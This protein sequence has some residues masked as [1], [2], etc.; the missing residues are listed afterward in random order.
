MD[1]QEIK[2]KVISI[3]SEY[4]P[5]VSINDRLQV[6]SLD[7]ISL[8]LDLE[9]SF[10]I[11]IDEI[12]DKIHFRNCKIGKIINYINNKINNKHHE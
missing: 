5:N 10:N 1:K 9:K 8:Q 4:Q 11:E 2:D 7:N 12:T 6:D 3:I